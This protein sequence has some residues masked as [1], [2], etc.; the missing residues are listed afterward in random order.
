MRLD[1]AGGYEYDGVV[2]F[3]D[4][5]KT[6]G[7]RAVSVGSRRLKNVQAHVEHAHAMASARVRD[8]GIQFIEELREA[9]RIVGWVSSG[10]LLIW[11]DGEID[12]FGPIVFGT[13][14]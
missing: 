2:F 1:V 9:A 6:N 8:R 4:A 5:I 11:Q 13:G 3:G 7:V 10:L 14:F 12:Q